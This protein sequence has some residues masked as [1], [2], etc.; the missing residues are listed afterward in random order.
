RANPP[1]SRLHQ[2]GPDLSRAARPRGSPALAGLLT[3]SA[4]VE[5]VVDPPPGRESLACDM[6]GD[7]WLAA[8]FLD[9]MW[10]QIVDGDDMDFTGSDP[11]GP[12]AIPGTCAADLGAVGGIDDHADRGHASMNSSITAC[13]C[14]A[15]I[16]SPAAR[17]WLR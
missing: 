2:T 17:A 11:A 1:D 13:H 10:L 16:S 14:M 15:R 6:Q 8:T 5:A 7:L 12:P 9:A 3:E 4:A